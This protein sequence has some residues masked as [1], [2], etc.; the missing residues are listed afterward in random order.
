M[1]IWKDIKWYEWLYQVSSYGRIKS[2]IHWKR[3]NKERIRKF[4]I[5]KVYSRVNLSKNKKQKHFF[6]HRL[7]AQA[8]LNFDID[9]SLSVCHYSEKTINW[10]LNN[11]VSNLWIWTHKD[12]MQDRENKWRNGM[13]WKTF[14]EEHR[15]KISEAN[16]WCIP[17]NKWKTNY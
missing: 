17:W 11:M 5:K 1:E 7:V 16:K 13:L 2:L 14:S 8:F 3:R 6:V 4:H 10:L 12:N 15:R 9:S